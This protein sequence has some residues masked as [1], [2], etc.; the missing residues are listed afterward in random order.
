VAEMLVT[1][2]DDA[3]VFFTVT[4]FAVFVFTTAFV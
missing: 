2:T 3:L 1:L 4:V